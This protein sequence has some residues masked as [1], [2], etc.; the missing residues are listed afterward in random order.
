MRILIL[1]LSMT[2]VVISICTSPHREMF[3][4]PYNNPINYK[5]KNINESLPRELMLNVKYPTAFYYELNNDVFEV[6]LKHCFNLQSTKIAQDKQWE[7][8]AEKSVQKVYNALI[9][10]IASLLIANAHH[11]KLPDGS[12]HPLQIVHDKLLQTSIHHT[13][14]SILMK[15]EFIFYREGKYQG[16][17]V[18]A[19]CMWNKDRTFTYLDMRVVGTVFADNIGMW[20][21]RQ[22][23]EFFEINTKWR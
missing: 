4:T 20:P 16:K 3:V 12:S 22:F 13:K 6:A 9:E 21:V 11:F 23:D 19:L 14:R 10:D 1:I 17:H 8:I 18:H 5:N 7:P 2:I 15:C